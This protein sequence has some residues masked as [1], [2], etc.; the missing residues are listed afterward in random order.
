MSQAERNKLPV[1]DIEAERFKPIIEYFS[2]LFPKDR[3]LCITEDLSFR[4]YVPVIITGQS[5]FPVMRTIFAGQTF[6]GATFYM[7]NDSLRVNL[8]PVT[9]KEV[10]LEGE[11]ESLILDMLIDT[12][13]FRDLEHVYY[14]QKF[15]DIKAACLSQESPDLKRQEA[16]DRVAKKRKLAK[17][18][19]LQK[20]AE[21]QQ[22][23]LINPFIGSW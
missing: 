18:I 2:N 9:P 22:Q 17:E 15:Q 20:E 4:K 7:K 11:V 14:S 1:D 3:V 8:T 19:S 10:C 16:K 5:D 12:A 21:L 13:A 6:S 23:L